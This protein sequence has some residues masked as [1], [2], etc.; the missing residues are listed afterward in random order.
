MRAARTNTPRSRTALRILGGVLLLGAALYLAACAAL[1][2]YQRSF[3][4]F[5]QPADSAHPAVTERL[6]IA[7]AQ[8]LA[9]VR[10]HAGPGAVVFFGGNG[11]AAALQL[12][13]LA[14]AFPDR[15]IYLLNYRSYGGSTGEAT[16]EALQSD[17]L[18]LSDLVVSRHPDTIVIGRSLGSGIA[19][20]VAARR[21]VSSL[22]L[23]TPFNSILELA[24]RRFPAFP[25]RWLLIDKYESW[26]YAPEVRSPTLLIAAERDRV[27]PRWST[28]KLYAAFGAGV[29]SLVVIPDV[30][31]GSIVASAEYLRALQRAA[32]NRTGKGPPVDG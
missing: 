6:P 19:I 29:A 26:R 16:E 3:L 8:V 30:G 23:V 17:A 27:V 31:H 24:E 11:D 14:A 12:P 1:A 4:Y 25:V 22:V 13:P 15:A 20:R 21:P 32:W 5:P 2:Y 7:G 10:E 28:D 18:V 9:T